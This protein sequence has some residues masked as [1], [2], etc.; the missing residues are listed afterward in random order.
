MTT[1]RPRCRDWYRLS[2]E[3]QAASDRELA[4]L[5]PLDECDPEHVRR[6]A[7]LLGLRPR[8]TDSA[9]RDAEDGGPA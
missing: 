6:L 9:R 7:A 3:Q 8:G 2:P 4:K 5:R 1:E